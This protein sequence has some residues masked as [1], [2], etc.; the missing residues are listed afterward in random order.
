MSKAPE[1]VFSLAFEPEM[2]LVP[3]SAMMPVR[4]LRPTVKASHKYRQ[5]SQSIREIGL[6]EPPVVARTDAAPG[7]YLLL[8]GRIRV[9]VLKEMGETQVECLVSTDD[10][11]FTY[12]RAVNRLSSIQERAMIVRAIE[13]GVPEGKIATAMSLDVKSVQRRVKMLDGICQEV[14]A[15][16]A[17]KHCPMAVFDVLR[18]MKPIRQMEAAD[19]FVGGNN[20]TVAYASAILAG[21][22]QAQLVDGV[23][24]KPKGV[25]ATLLARMERELATLQES[26][27]SAEETYSRDNL[28]L[29]VFKG[30]L[31]KL[32]GNARVA[33]FLASRY[34]DFLEQFQAIADI[35]STK[36]ADEA[37]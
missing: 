16:L 33:R 21:S 36:P 26:I 31:A 18:K 5:I 14:V 1:P 37:A 3:I 29:T 25:S 4:A 17:D 9:E 35:V 8:D 34:P 6:V 22:S 19:L 13:R 11:A 32:V 30:Y 7:R 10:E 24:A 12:N 23:K 15:Q 2:A 27:G 28:H 20:Y